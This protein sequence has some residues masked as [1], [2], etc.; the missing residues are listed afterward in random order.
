VSR[1][2]PEVQVGVLRC[3]GPGVTAALSMAGEE[4]AAIN[5]GTYSEACDATYGGRPAS[6]CDQLLSLA[7]GER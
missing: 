7:Q 6:R 3:L 4:Q 2:E 1:A 5:P